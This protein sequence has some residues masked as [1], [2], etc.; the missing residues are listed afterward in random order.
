MLRCA[1]VAIWLWLLLHR[2][3]QCFFFCFAASKPDG[4]W[5][6]TRP[7]IHIQLERHLRAAAVLTRLKAT[8]RFDAMS[9]GGRA[10]DSR[11]YYTLN[12]RPRD[13][14]VQV[15]WCLFGVSAQC[16]CHARRV[17]TTWDLLAV[18][19]RA[20]AIQKKMHDILDPILGCLSLF[21]LLRCGATSAWSQARSLCCVLIWK[22]HGSRW[23]TTRVILHFIFR[24]FSSL[25]QSAIFLFY[26]SVFFPSSDRSDPP[27]G[28]R[29]CCDGFGDIL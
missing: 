2:I 23:E 6:W 12:E 14:C 24:H 4:R 8:H 28:R 13:L 22:T 11:F 10:G 20:P 29:R 21:L 1:R 16:R 9:I 17:L 7:Y 19:R 27:L 3:V 26:F 18:V 5:P 25:L 15:F